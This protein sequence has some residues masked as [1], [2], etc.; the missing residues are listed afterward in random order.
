[1]AITNHERVEKM[2]G[3]IHIEFQTLGYGGRML[4]R[5]KLKNF[6]SWS[7]TRD[8]ALKPITGFFGA[9]SSGKTSLLQALLLLK[10]TSDSADRGLALQFGEK[11]SLVDLGDFRSVIH[12]HAEGSE[13]LFE[14]DWQVKKPFLGDRS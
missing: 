12:G 10:Q 6:K 3:N 1:M 13:L 2:F 9:N 14:F 5:L 11:S 7:D 4:T 8:L